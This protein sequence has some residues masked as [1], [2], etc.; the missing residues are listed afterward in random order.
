MPYFYHPGFRVITDSFIH[1]GPTM[2]AL[3]AHLEDILD[4]MKQ[5]DMVLVDFCDLFMQLDCDQDICNY[6]I[7]NHS[8][9]RL[10]WLE[11]ISSEDLC[12]PYAVSPAQLR[13]SQ[14][15]S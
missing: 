15:S 13:Q 6:Y 3:M 9:R 1:D 12:L 8:Q 5:R 2:S 4:L 14:I 7:A 11:D 10:S